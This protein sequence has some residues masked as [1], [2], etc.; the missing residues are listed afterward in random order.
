MPSSS[1]PIRRLAQIGGGERQA[2]VLAVGVGEEFGER[3]VVHG[4]HDAVNL[5]LDLPQMRLQPV[6][7]D[8]EELRVG[9]VPLHADA[10]HPA[11]SGWP[12]TVAGRVGVVAG[13]Q[14]RVLLEHRRR[15]G[16]T[17]A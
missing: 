13:K 7:A 16:E 14:L 4:D 1:S 10:V 8:L 12:A 11:G 3:N 6:Q 9:P 17:L 2:V 5:G 15:T